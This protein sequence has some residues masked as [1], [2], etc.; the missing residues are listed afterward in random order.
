MT[1]SLLLENGKPLVR[2]MG[3][4]SE[5]T[6]LPRGKDPVRVASEDPNSKNGSDA[7]RKS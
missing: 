2:L 6:S 3:M 5:Y 4:G 1:D 7:G